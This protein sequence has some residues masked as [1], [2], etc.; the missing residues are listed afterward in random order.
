MARRA[1]EEEQ[2]LAEQTPV[3]EQSQETQSQETES[4]TGATEPDEVEVELF[5]DNGRYKDDVVVGVNGKLYVI[6]RGVRVKVPRAVK[7]IL[8]HSRE[9]DTQTAL[10]MDSLENHYQEETRKYNV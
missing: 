2:V 8:D 3:E 1:S 7:E 4:C 6:K 5:K 10:M 9:Q